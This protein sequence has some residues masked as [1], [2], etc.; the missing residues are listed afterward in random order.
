MSSS[1]ALKWVSQVLLRTR[2]R[3]LSGNFNPLLVGELLWE[4]SSNWHQLAMD[5]I[6]GVAHVCSHFLAALPQVKCPKDIHSRIWSSLIQDA[7]KSRNEASVEELGLIMKDVR[8]YPINYNH[9]YTDMIRKRRQA[10]GKKALTAC[11]KSATKHVFVSTLPSDTLVKPIGSGGSRV[12]PIIS[13]AL[14]DYIY[15]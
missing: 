8:S 12:L 15:M 2:G 14:Y 4:Q 6:E 3:E 9:Y 5:H 10:R 1:E 13:R 7:L 11:I